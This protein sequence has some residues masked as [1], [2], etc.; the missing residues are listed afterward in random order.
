VW[1]A[2]LLYRRSMEIIWIAIAVLLTWGG[3]F[4]LGLLARIPGRLVY[5]AR[6]KADQEA[7]QVKKG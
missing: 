2:Y 1:L 7:V 4:L 5:E 3:T 6:M